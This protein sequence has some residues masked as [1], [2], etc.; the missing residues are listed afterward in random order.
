MTEW[1]RSLM[2]TLAAAG[3]MTLAVAGSSAAS[4]L[5]ISPGS[6][7]RTSS[8]LEAD[9]TISHVLINEGARESVPITV[10]FDPQVTGVESGEVF[11]N[12]D[13]RDWATAAPNDDVSKK[14]SVPRPATASQREMIATTT[15]LIQ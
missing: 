4:S 3:L 1:N 7:Q 13:R 8:E 9:Y 15:R 10:F 2:T 6:D 11:T 5:K 12:L 14:G